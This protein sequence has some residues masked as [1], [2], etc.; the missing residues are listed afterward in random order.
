MGISTA[1]R[2]PQGIR[3]G[4]K[5]ET[6]F[7]VGLD[8]DLASGGDTTAYLLQPVLSPPTPP[9]F[10]TFRESRLAAGRGTVKNAADTIVNHRGG[11]ITMPFEM[12]ATP[13]TLAQH[14]LLVGQEN[15]QSGSIVHEM[16][17]DGESNPTSIGEAIGGDGIPHSCNLMYDPVEGDSQG[18]RVTGVICSDLTI[19]G[20]VGSNNGI[21]TLSGNYFSGFSNPLT[22]ATTNE[23]NFAGTEVAAET[24]Y[25]LMHN[26]STKTLTCDDDVS[27]MILRS[28]TFNIT[29][30]VTRMG[31]NTNG[32]AEGYAFTEY[33]VTGNLVVKHDAEFS[34]KAADNVLQDFLDGDTLAL[35]INI[36]DG[37]VSSEGEC[38]IAAQIQYTGQPDL[39]LGE[40]GIYLNLPFECVQNSSTEA[41]K[42][43]S[44]KNEAVTAW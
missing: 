22:T 7:G 27:T 11:T 1:V 2:P 9:I 15:G 10:N 18:T 33:A 36:G 17:I 13:R 42:I 5:A 24:T 19:S 6:A 39:D 3:L 25:Y 4:L 44:F 26:M 20:D 40:G 8:T 21:V 32:D 29:N 35:A 30:G 12:Y 14:C 37:T 43:T 34:F 28:F 31:A 41:F 38:N 23:V 16:E